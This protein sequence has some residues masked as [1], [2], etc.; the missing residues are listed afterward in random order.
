MVWL[1]GQVCVA[2]GMSWSP[3]G[4]VRLY[5]FWDQEDVQA[6]ESTRRTHTFEM[7]LFSTTHVGARVR[8][9]ESLA[10]WAEMSITEE[11][12][13]L[14]HLVGYWDMHD[15]RVTISDASS[16]SPGGRLWYD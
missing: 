12:V 13:R 10:G 3:Y 1:A 14:R 4:S 6:G 9:D 15:Y 11:Q 5:S 2:A 8:W 16:L 7:G